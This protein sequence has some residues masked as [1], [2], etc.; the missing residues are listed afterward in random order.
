MRVQLNTY[1]M[2]FQNGSTTAG[3]LAECG[4]L[5]G[6]VPGCTVARFRGKGCAFVGFGH[7]VSGW[8]M[9]SMDTVWPP[10]TPLPVRAAPAECLVETHGP[11]TGGRGW[12][13][14]NSGNGSVVVPFDA[15]TPP[16]FP[17]AAA[18]GQPAWPALGL[19]LPGLFKSEFGATSFSSFESL[20]ATLSGPRNWGAHA[21]AM[22]WRSY[23]QDSIV[24]SFFGGPGAGA[25]VNMSVVGDAAVFAR[26]LLL[27]QLAAA[28]LVKSEVET[29]RSGNYFGTMLWQ[30]GEIFPTG[31]WGSLEYAHTTASTLS[32]GG[33]VR[34]G[35]WKPLHYWFERFLFRD[36]LVACGDAAACYVRNDAPLVPV[37]AGARVELELVSVATGARRA[38]PP[39]AL[40][41]L[42]AGPAAITWFCAGG[43]GGDGGNSSS[44]SSRSSSSSSS[45]SSSVCQPW[46]A[47]LAAVGCLPDG[48]DCFLNATVVDASG[49]ALSSNP[50]LLAP[51]AAMLKHLRPPQLAAAVETPAPPAG[52]PIRVTV[53]AAAPALFVTLSTLAQGRFSR[54]AFI[55][56]AGETELLF[57]PT[58]GEG[59]QYDA[60][61]KSLMVLSV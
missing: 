61:Q 44:S 26:Q 37:A 32:T 14:V 5:C 25:A 48:A 57:L 53:T 6:A 28:L 49:A 21:P 45:S 1:Y 13:A 31:G 2:G 55:A 12:P 52:A 38:L 8:G 4:A 59:D 41:P 58:A 10:A 15:A 23:S 51:P 22:Y 39:R 35:R 60:L 50:S 9:A 20:S 42:P 36:V 43:G 46:S 34:G 33:Q 18:A 19:R 24:A 29:Q 40:P 47:V 3:S 56:A 27:S 17:A 30:L 7:P 16:H 11:Y 54:N